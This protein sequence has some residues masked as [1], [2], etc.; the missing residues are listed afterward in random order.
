MNDDVGTTHHHH[1]P[2]VADEGSCA[3][4]Q[5]QSCIE[6]ILVVVC[7]IGNIYFGVPG[8]RPC[9]FG[10]TRVYTRLS[11]RYMQYYI[12]TRGSRVSLLSILAILGCIISGII[13]YIPGSPDAYMP[14]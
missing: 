2:V 1:L 12:I 10:R 5:N 8:Y 9:L 7:E 14:C 3:R 13:E 11:P 6:M 4:W